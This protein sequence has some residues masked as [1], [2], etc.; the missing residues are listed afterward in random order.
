MSEELKKIIHDKNI[1]VKEWITYDVFKDSKVTELTKK[2]N[3][4]EKSNIYLNKKNAILGRKINNMKQIISKLDDK[5]YYTSKEINSYRKRFES[6]LNENLDLKRNCDNL[7]DE[8]INLKRCRDELENKYETLRE[9]KRRKTNDELLRVFKKI[10][11]HD[12]EETGKQN[13]EQ[14]IEFKNEL[15]EILKKIRNINDI[16]DLKN[17]DKDKQ[18]IFKRNYKFNKLINIIEPLEQLQQMVGLTKIKEQIFEHICYFI[19][20][21]NDN[22]ELMNIV[23]SG[24]SGVGKSE[25]GKIISKLYLSLGFLKNNKFIIAT[26]T[27]LIGKYLGHTASKTKEVCK[28]A[29][30]GVLFIDEV[31]SL[32]NGNDE[33]IDSFSKECIDTLNQELTEHKGEL[34]CIIA[35]YEDEIK[36]CFFNVNSGLERRFPIKYKIDNY[37]ANELREMTLKKLKE[38]KVKDD[39]VLPLSFFENNYKAF[40]FFGGTVELL[41]QEAKFIAGKRMLYETEINKMFEQ[42][43]FDLALKKISIGIEEKPFPFEL[44]L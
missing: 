2:I 13:I 29:V 17:M 15:I 38:W 3:N 40:K 30:G 27:D 39:S 26:R 33:H 11:R 20:N 42:S 10:K 44:Y 12:K 43:D 5:N 14:T 21:L 35:G 24:T 7:S 31:Y 34:L 16:I 6:L 9:C 23:I 32:G 22:N 28:N 19:Q 37:N 1:S 36:K 25:L 41:V 18:L 4:Y 8:N